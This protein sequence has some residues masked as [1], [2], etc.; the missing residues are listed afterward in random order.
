MNWLKKLGERIDALEE[1]VVPGGM[2]ARMDEFY[3]NAIPMAKEG[4]VKAKRWAGRMYRRTRNKP[5]PMARVDDKGQSV[6]VRTA[7]D[8]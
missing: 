6:L 1:R 2:D 5:V 7:K 4:Y 8:C 3:E